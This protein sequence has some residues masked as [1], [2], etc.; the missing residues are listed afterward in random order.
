IFTILHTDQDKTNSA[1][2]RQELLERGLDV[3]AHHPV[4]GVGVG[5]YGI[6]SIRKLVAHNSYIETAAELGLAGFV[7]Y[8]V[9]IFA[10][11]RSLR[12]IERDTYARRAAWDDTERETY[13][14]SVGL[15][16]VIISYAVCSF[17]QS[18][19]YTWYL[20]YLVAYTVSLRRIRASE[21][22]ATNQAGAHPN[23]DGALWSARG[24]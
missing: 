6:Y 20:Y 14:I 7:A 3:I 18:A 1:Q 23:T 11:L 5:N 22:H 4:I 16:A 24:A 21:A 2:E 17:F 10:P 9:L 13:Y 12:R 8:L 19:Q 15:Q